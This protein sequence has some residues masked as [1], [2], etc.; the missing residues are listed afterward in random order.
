MYADDDITYTVW[1]SSTRSEARAAMRTKPLFFSMPDI[2]ENTVMQVCTRSMPY[3]PRMTSSSL[4]GSVSPWKTL[5][6]ALLKVKYGPSSSSYSA[7]SGNYFPMGPS[8][9]PQ[10]S[11]EGKFLINPFRECNT[12]WRSFCCSAE[13]SSD[14]VVVWWVSQRSFFFFNIAPKFV[15]H[16]LWLRQLVCSVW[17]FSGHWFHRTWWTINM[18]KYRVRIV[19]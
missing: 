6:Y 9:A 13:D 2:F 14:M 15:S 3:L 12:C 17:R 11:D 4:S 1:Q 19:L 5:S 7:F 18:I 10:G 8:L 16:N